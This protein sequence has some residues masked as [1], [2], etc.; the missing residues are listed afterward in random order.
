MK[1]F[2]L[3]DVSSMGRARRSCGP[4]KSSFAGDEEEDVAVGGCKYFSETRNVDG[5]NEMGRRKLHTM[6]GLQY[7]GADEG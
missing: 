6:R 1:I 5:G 7:N 2:R 4:L 3:I